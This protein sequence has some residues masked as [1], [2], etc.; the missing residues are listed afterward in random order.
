MYKFRYGESN[1]NKF[2]VASFFLMG[3][4]YIIGF[5]TYIEGSFSSIKSDF[6]ARNII[7]DDIRAQ[8]ALKPVFEWQWQFFTY[9]FIH[10][11]LVHYAYVGLFIF[12]YVP[13]LEKATSSKFVII[14]FFIR[15]VSNKVH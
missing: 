6:F 9:G 15:I 12:Y 14:S 3:L 7:V 11:G 2:P 10:F 4:F 1:R 8:F 5:L 13:G